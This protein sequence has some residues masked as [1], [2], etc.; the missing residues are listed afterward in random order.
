MILYEFDFFFG[1]PGSCN[2]INVLNN[3]KIVCNILNGTYPPHIKYSIGIE[4]H[5]IPYWIVDGI[6][7]N[8]PCF[9]HTVVEPVTEKEKLMAGAQEAARKD[10]ERVFA[11]LQNK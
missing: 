5:N 3:S 1:M 11:V 2:D 10:V 6:Y 4:K 7:P 9:L 8:W